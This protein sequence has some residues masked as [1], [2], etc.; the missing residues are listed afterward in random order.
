[1]WNGAWACSRKVT[2][3]SGCVCISF[4]PVNIPPMKRMFIWMASLYSEGISRFA[5]WIT[6]AAGKNLFSISCVPYRQLVALRGYCCR[7]VAYDFVSSNSYVDAGVCVLRK[8]F[9]FPLVQV[10][11]CSSILFLPAA[12]D[13]LGLDRGDYRFLLC[14]HLSF[15]V[16]LNHRRFPHQSISWCDLTFALNILPR[17]LSRH[18]SS[19]GVF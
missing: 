5:M 3:C 11:K 14:C 2:T 8:C 7:P 15:S 12:V 10:I 18:L 4:L 19:F 6:N 1:M 13:D 16:P 17:V 9:V